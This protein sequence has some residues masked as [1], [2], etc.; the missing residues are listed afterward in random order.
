MS[1]T[2]ATDATLSA[3]GTITISSAARIAATYTASGAISQKEGTIVLSSATGGLAMT[4]AAPTSG[5]DD[6][7]VLRIIDVTPNGD[8]GSA[9]TVTTSNDSYGD[10]GSGQPM[11]NQLDF[12][13]AVGA[14]S[15]G[16]VAELFAYSGHWYLIDASSS[17]RLNLY[18]N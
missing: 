3:T 9:N 4:L 14:T 16:F 1:G 13:T 7:K 6:G 5:T 15:F 11:W 2:I 12:N 17:T 10:G 8:G 18:Y